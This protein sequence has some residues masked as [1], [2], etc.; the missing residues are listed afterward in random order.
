VFNE[1]FYGLIKQVLKH[2]GE[3]VLMSQHHYP[4]EEVPVFNSIKLHALEVG[5]KLMFDVLAYAFYNTSMA[6]ITSSL[7]SIIQFADSGFSL[8]RGMSSLILT[9]I[10]KYFLQDSLQRFITIMFTCNDKTSR[11][12]IGKLASLLINKAFSCVH[13]CNSIIE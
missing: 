1:G 8:S 6:D 2:I 11:N 10:D 12:Y 7:S 13:E 5:F 3:K 4:L 9:F